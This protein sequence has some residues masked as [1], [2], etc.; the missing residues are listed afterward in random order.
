MVSLELH[1]VLGGDAF[2]SVGKPIGIYPSPDGK[3]TAVAG[4]TGHYYWPGLSLPGRRFRYSVSVYRTDTLDR[5]ASIDVEMH[6]VNHVAWH[7]TE[8]I[9]SVGCGSY[10]GGYYFEGDLILWDLEAG[11]H[12]AAL[13]WSRQIEESWFDH[14]DNLVMIALPR[15]DDTGPW[16]KVPLYE[17]TV[18]PR[19]WRRFKKKCIPAYDGLAEVETP[20]RASDEKPQR[21]R[22][23]ELTELT[24][25]GG[26]RYEPRWEIWDIDWLTD[27]RILCTRN[28]T[29]LEMWSESGER[30][31]LQ[32]HDLNG[33]QVVVSPDERY[34]LVNLWGRRFEERMWRD[35]SELI[36]FDLLTLESQVT[37]LTFP[38][39]LSISDTGHI[40][41]RDLTM[42]MVEERDEP[43]HD[44]VISPDGSFS[45]LDLGFADNYIRI[46]GAEYLY[47]IR[48]RKG[49]SFPRTGI[50]WFLWMLLSRLGLPVVLPQ[51]VYRLDPLSMKVEPGFAIEWNR[52]R[53]K[54]LSGGASLHLR[55]RNAVL[56]ASDIYDPRGPARELN[57]RD[58]A[59]GKLLWTMSLQ[60]A[61]SCLA[62]FESAGI[63]A[64]GTR[65]GK[66]GLANMA[67][68]KLLWR[69]PAGPAG[70][71]TVV[72]SMSARGN[73]VA[74]GTVDGR[75]L[76]YELVH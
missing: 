57:C 17:V 42:G 73:R 36:R 38:A 63:V 72:L 60:S 69:S 49:G 39:G 76:I 16:E 4:S 61:V 53:N 23:A 27:G 10:D 68:G 71:P 30:S 28:N 7:P 48:G 74:C 18:P 20:R 31:F 40:L 75:I 1:E 29:A 26:R 43:R 11:V 35:E 45:E 41:A 54:L 62:E 5:I 46:D 37:Q 59:A 21:D 70:E 44:V 9:L 24:A 47:F 58:L 67:D 13:D 66:I 6:P 51:W 34:A 12:V 65:R 33:V 15:N 19:I 32:S 55:R 52:K 14:E 2:A 56:I 8:A 3:M 25:S 50:P 22:V 64:I